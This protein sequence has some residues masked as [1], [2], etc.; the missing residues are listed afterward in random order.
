MGGSGGALHCIFI[1]FFYS[2]LCLRSAEIA[3]WF[4]CVWSLGSFFFSS[5][6]VYSR[7]DRWHLQC[8]HT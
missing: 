5:G 6:C 8:M 2:F 1:L 7:V 3:V 4:C